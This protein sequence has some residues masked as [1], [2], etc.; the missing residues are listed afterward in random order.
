M[1]EMDCLPP[2]LRTMA[3]GDLELVRSWRN[4]PEVRRYMYSQNE[5]G[6]DEHASWF[7]SASAAHD[8]VLLIL[9]IHGRPC[10]YVN[11]SI[12]ANGEGYWGF[13]LAPDMPKGTGTVLGRLAMDYAFSILDLGCVW[14]EVLPENIVSQHFH[15]KLGFVLHDVLPELTA[16]NRLITNVHRYVLTRAVWKMYKEEKL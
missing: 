14:G 1:D 6:I 8:R 4:H 13:Y 16:G 5:I 11:F 3:L 10:G 9:E 7:Q 12:H 2:I 15:L